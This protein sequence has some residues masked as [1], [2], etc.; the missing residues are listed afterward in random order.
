MSNSIRLLFNCAAFS[1][2]VLPVQSL[3][4]AGMQ[5]E[6]SVVLVDEGKGEA[7]IKI[8]N[9]DSASALLHTSLETIAE[10][11]EVLL[12]ATP[13][14]ARVEA[15]ETQLVRFIL[16]SKAPL[17]HQRLMRVTFEGIPMSESKKPNSVGVTYRQNLPVIISPKGLA[18]ESAPWKHLK[19]SMCN[20]KLRVVNDSPYV[21]RMALQGSLLPSGGQINFPRTYLLPNTSLD[22]PLASGAEVSASQVRIHPASVYGYAVKQYE[23]VLGAC[24]SKN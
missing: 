4:A 21:V 17:Q 10:D 1:L 2:V 22:L 15:G 12:F 23:A 18:P 16:Q 6:T 3:L 11:P 5:P 20:Q 9:T 8:T 24:Q 13:P 7:E 14:V 19:W